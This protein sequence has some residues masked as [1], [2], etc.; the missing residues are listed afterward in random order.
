MENSKILEE[1]N[2]CG[3]AGCTTRKILMREGVNHIKLGMFYA[4]DPYFR[5]IVNKCAAYQLHSLQVFVSARMQL[6]VGLE[7][8]AVG[9]QIA[10]E[11]AVKC[12]NGRYKLS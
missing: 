5:I 10:L 1:E 8:S 9:T 11:Q 12:L 4:N 3:K 2:C 7:V 6:K